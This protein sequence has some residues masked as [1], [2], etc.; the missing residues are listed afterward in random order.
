MRPRSDQNRGAT[1]W[2]SVHQNSVIFK[3]ISLTSNFLHK[4]RYLKKKKTHS[5]VTILSRGDR[6]PTVSD[7]E[8]R[9]LVRKAAKTP[10]ETHG[11]VL[12]PPRFT[13]PRLLSSD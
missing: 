6:P 8:K 3:K 5:Y 11:V 13:V 4:I 7:R 10:K 9:G 1:F 2:K 12:P